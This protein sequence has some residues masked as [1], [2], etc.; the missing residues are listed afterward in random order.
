MA[1][2]QKL[3]HRSQ[4]WLGSGVA[5]AGVQACNCSS[6]STLAWER[7]YATGVAL[8]KTKVDSIQVGCWAESYS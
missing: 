7:P 2:L 3:Q 6:H 5:V 1:L 8:K 4:V